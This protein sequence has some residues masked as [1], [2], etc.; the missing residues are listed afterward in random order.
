MKV[1][2]AS[3]PDGLSSHMLQNTA[4]TIYSSLTDLFNKSLSTGVVPLRWK[5]SN[6]TPVFKGQGNP[7]SVSN[8]RPIS[9]LSLPSKVLERI[10]HNC[11]MNYLLS[12]N[13]LSSRQFGFRPRSSTQEALLYTTNDWHYHMDHGLSV[14]SGFF[15]LSKAFD[16]VPHSQ[17]ISTLANIGVSGPLLAWFH[18]YLSDRSQ[19]VVLDGHSSTIHTVT[20]GVPQGSILD[21]LL[22]SIYLNPLANISLSRDS[23]LILYADDIVLY[24]PIATHSDVESLQADVDKVSNWVKAAGLSLNAKMSKVVFSRKRAP[25][26]VNILVCHNVIPVVESTCF[27][28]VTISCDLKWNTHITNTCTK[29]RQQLGLLYRLFGIADP[30]SL[31]HLYKCLILPTLDYCS[32][33]WDPAAAYLI[34]RLESVQRLA[35]RLTTKRWLASPDNLI[36]FLNWTTLRA[37]QKKQKDKVMVCAHIINGCSIIPP[38]T[39]LFTLILIKDFITRAHSLLLL[40]EPLHIRHH[41]S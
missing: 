35:A 29:A 15:D 5:L 12:N 26:V 38:H 18:S 25:P 28:G 39:F 24:R 11:L 1:K 9:L 33:V 3:G 13:V 32:V 30:V 4:S 34:N 40:V 10:I 23:T 27:L 19:R 7:S 21:P 17:L 6:I 31:A 41:F 37:R 2:T 22:F 36:N 20:S 14:A 16:R 8:Y